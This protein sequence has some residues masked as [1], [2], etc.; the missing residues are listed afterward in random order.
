MAKR[1]LFNKS[2]SARGGEFSSS[3]RKAAT[4]LLRLFFFLLERSKLGFC[5]FPVSV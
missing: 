5:Y 1:H 3:K 4:I 2:I